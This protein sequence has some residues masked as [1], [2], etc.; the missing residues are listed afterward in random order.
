MT[1]MMLNNASKTKS[2][3]TMTRLFALAL[4]TI[5]VFAV[6]PQANAQVTLLNRLLRNSDFQT[7]PNPISTGCGVVNC[8]APPQLIF[9]VLNAV[10]PA[11][12]N[13]TCTFYI[14]LETQAHLSQRDRGLFQF[15]VD[16]AAPVPGPTDPGGFFTWD[17][18]DPDSAVAVPFAHSYA[19]TAIV[20]NSVAN[21]A[22]QVTVS[23][24]CFDTN[25]SGACA[26]ATGLANLEVNIY[27]P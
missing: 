14:H 11:A 24:S 22:H 27:T 19:V 15:L 13:A 3:A 4:A 12:A 17:D 6:L 7:E 1:H 21:Q 10:C 8:L 25:A 2:S 16:A 9:P 23:V 5:L 20:K 18:R 26:V